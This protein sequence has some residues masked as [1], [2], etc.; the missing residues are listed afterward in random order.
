MQKAEAKKLY[1][2]LNRFWGVSVRKILYV[3]KSSLH[4]KVRDCK[5]YR[6]AFWM[7]NLLDGYRRP[8]QKEFYNM[9][10][11]KLEEVA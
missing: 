1:Q 3:F 11:I 4:G 8:T 6:Y 5:H 10:E 2:K 9:Y 7:P